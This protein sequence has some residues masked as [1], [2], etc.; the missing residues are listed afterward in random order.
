[1]RLALLRPST[2]HSHLRHTRVRSRTVATRAIRVSPDGQRI[3]FVDGG[4]GPDLCVMS[5]NGW[6]LKRVIR[7]CK[8]GKDLRGES[9]GYLYFVRDGTISRVKP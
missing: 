7:G 1:M 8:D 2:A 3:S 4:D 9:D 6:N 5:I